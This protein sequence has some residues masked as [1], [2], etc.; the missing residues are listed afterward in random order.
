MNQLSTEHL[1]AQL[2]ESAQLEESQLAQALAESRLYMESAG[3]R[4]IRL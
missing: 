2:L 1:H 4:E 3:E